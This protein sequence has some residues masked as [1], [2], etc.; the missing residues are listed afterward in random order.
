GLEVLARHPLRR[1]VPAHAVLL[2]RPVASAPTRVDEIQ[3]LLAGETVIEDVTH[4]ALDARLVLGMPWPR[5]VDVE[6]ARLCV[7]EVVLDDARLAR[8]GGVHDR[9]GAVGHDDAEHATVELPRGLARLERGRR[10]LLPARIDE[11]VTRHMRR[12]DPR[13]EPAT[14]AAL[15]GLEQR[16]PARVDVDLLAGLAVGDRDRRGAL[17]EAE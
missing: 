8:I 10:R 7:L 2:G 3:Q 9:L 12:E 1:R 14:P 15:V 17:T 16:H 13:A 5:R 6:A 4:S 11:P